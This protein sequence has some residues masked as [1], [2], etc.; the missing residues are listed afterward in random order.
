MRQQP[1]TEDPAPTVAAAMAAAEPD[2]GG[3]PACW[4]HLICADCGAVVSEGHRQGCDAA[5][6]GG[7]WS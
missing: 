2:A 4:A 1:R 6:P 5:A 3:E 7:S